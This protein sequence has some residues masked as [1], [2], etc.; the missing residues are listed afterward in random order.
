MCIANLASISSIVVSAVLGSLVSACVDSDAESMGTVRVNL[1][2]QTASGAVYRLRDA[3]LTVQ[4][5][6]STQVWNTEDNPDRTALSAHVASGPYQATLSPGWRIER[7]EGLSTTTVPAELM[8]ANPIAFAVEPQ[9]RT[10]V[11]LVFRVSHE[12]VDLGQGYDVVLDIAESEV[13]PNGD[14]ATADANGAF[15]GTAHVIGSISPAGDGDVYAF[16]NPTSAVVVIKL[17]TWNPMLGV[18][19]PCGSTIDTVLAVRDG[20]GNLIGL[21]GDRDGA[22]DRCS[23]VILDVPPGQRIYVQIRDVGDD[24]TIPSYSVTAQYFAL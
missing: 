12:E 20:A 11:P 24:D 6:Q 4:G 2:G 14:A 8:S 21:A 5:P 22:A 1:V 7:V 18:G 3:V 9:Q 23:N 15:G 10:T 13:E 19:V 16:V 17:D